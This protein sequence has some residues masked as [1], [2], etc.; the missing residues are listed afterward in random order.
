MKND[1]SYFK[2]CDD[3]PV[4]QVSWND[5]REFIG[6]LNQYARAN[7]IAYRFKLP[8]EAQWEYAARAET[9]TPFY[10]GRCLSTDQ[11]NYDGNYPLEG[12]EKEGKIKYRK[13]TVDLKALGGG[14]QEQV[15]ALRNA[16]ERIQMVFR[17][18][19][20]VSARKGKSESD[21]VINPEVDPGGTEKSADRVLRG[22]GWNDDARYCRSADRGSCGPG[23]RDS[24]A[25]GTPATRAPL[26]EGP[27]PS[28]SHAPAWNACRT[29]LRRVPGWWCVLTR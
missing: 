7:G 22:G 21:P 11:A 14:F 10:F 16:R 19:R 8:S 12:C 17:Q 29:L 24:R 5:A 3:C 23:E 20:G 15:G 26:T 1:P 9:Q 27:L 6:K 2:N 13:K 18:I 25:P 28:R 4:E